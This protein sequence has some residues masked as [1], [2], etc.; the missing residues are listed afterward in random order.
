MKTQSHLTQLV[1]VFIAAVCLIGLS[2]ISY[3]QFNGRVPE[4]IAQEYHLGYCQMDKSTL[5]G[6]QD[7]LTPE[8]LTVKVYPNPFNSSTKIEI[9]LAESSNLTLQVTDLYGKLVENIFDGTLDAGNYT[10]NW[11][12]DR[13]AQGVYFLH[14]MTNKDSK[15]IKL[16]TE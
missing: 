7:A 15:T 5:A 4:Y 10:F 11:G 6:E 14:A 13:H 16:M 8:G 1:G 2:E 3:S 12:N 9:S